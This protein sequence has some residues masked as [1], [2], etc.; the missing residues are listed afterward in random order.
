M[1]RV[2]V[3]TMVQATFGL[4]SGKNVVDQK[5]LQIPIGEFTLE[6]F[7]EAFHKLEQGVAQLEASDP[8]G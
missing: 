7:I 6:A 4:V 5:P 1:Q 8:K 2:H 3:I